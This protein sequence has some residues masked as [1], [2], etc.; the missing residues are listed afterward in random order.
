LGTCFGLS[1]LS[2]DILATFLA[3][4]PNIR[5]ILAQLS[6]H[7]GSNATNTSLQIAGTKFVGLVKILNFTF[8]ELAVAK[9]EFVKLFL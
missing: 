5:R 6:G 2:F 7:S 3:T 9:S 4:I 1:I 8:D